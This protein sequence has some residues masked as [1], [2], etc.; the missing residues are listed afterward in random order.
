MRIFL[1]CLQPFINSGTL[2]AHMQQKF[3]IPELYFLYADDDQDDREAFVELIGQLEPAME[4]L[5]CKQ[6]LEL[7][8]FLESLDA[9]DPLPCCIILDMNMPLWDGLHTL[10]ELKKHPQYAH[11]STVMFTT[12]SADRD[13]QRSMALGAEAFITKPLRLVEFENVARQFSL[14]CAK[15]PTK[16]MELGIK[17][18]H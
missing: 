17:K 13:V 6:G 7:V 8:Q 2:N 3:P 9:G 5:T 1:L 18:P 16:K 11:V 10:A 14:F 15:T 12:S 4:V